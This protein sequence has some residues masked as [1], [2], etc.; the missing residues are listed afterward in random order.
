[1]KLSFSNLLLIILGLITARNSLSQSCANYSPVTRQTGIAYT[2]IAASS[3]SYFIWRN[4]AS[5]QN[6][7]NR[8]YQ[9]PIGFDFW[10][11]GVRYNQISASLNGV[12]DFSASTSQGN[13]PSG[14]SPYGSHWSNQFS[15]ANRT[16]LALAPLYGDL[17]TAN[18]GT[19]AIATSIFYKVTGTSPNQVLTVEW[20]N[21]DHWNLPTN[22]PNANYN[23]Q[24]KIYETTGVIEFVYG[25]MTA[26]AGGSY[27][28]QYACGINNT[29]T[30]GP[31]TPVRLLTQQTAN[32]TTFSST[33]KNNLTT[34]PASNSQLTFTPPTPN[35]T[36]PATLSF[37][38][39]TSSGMT[40]NFTDWCSNEVG[41]VVYNSTDNITFNFVTQTAAN[42]INYAATGLLPSTLYYWKVYAVTDGSL[43]SP[44]LGNQSTNAAGNKI[45]IA[46]GNWGTAGTWSPSGAP[47]AGDNVTI[48]N[49]HT[50]TINANN[51]TCNNLTVGQGA[52]GILRIGNNTTARIVTINNDIAI[53]TG[54]QFIANTGSNTTHNITV[55]GNII[56]NGTL[57]FASDGNSFANITFNKNG[58]QTISG[59]GA[60]TR[61]NRITVNM[62]TVNSNTLEITA[63]NFTV[64]STNFLTLTNGTFKLST[65]ATI[66][67]FTGNTT[68]PLSTGLWVNNASAV[69]NT[70]GGS[71]TLY[72]KLNVSSGTL[73]IGNATN[74]NLT[75]YG[76]VV[77][78]NG[79]SINIASRLD[80]AGTPTLSFFN[81]TNGTLTLNTVGSTTAGAAPFRMDEVG[82]TFNM[83]G[84]TIII[85]RSGAGN[86]GYVN[87]GSTGTVTGGTLQIGDA[88]TPAAQ[89]IQINST[90]EIGNLL[91]NSANANAILM[92]NSLVLTNDVTV[93]SG[94]LNAN[95]L[96]LTLGG[97]WLDN[98]TFT[99]GI[100]TV[101]FDGTNQSI[102]KTTGETF[103]HL[104]LTGTGTKT[105]G[106]NVTTNGDLTINAAA[107]LDITTN[108]YN[109]NVGSNW[110]NNGNFLAQNGTVTFNGTVAQ[111][112]GGT[113]IT[114]FRNITLNNSAGASLTNAQNLLGTLTL[115]FGTFA[116]NGQVFTLVSDASGTARIAT[117]PPFG[118]D[119]TGNIT[120]QRYIDAGATNWRFL[121]TAVSGTTLADWNDDFITSGFIGS[122][123]PLWPTP[124][125]PWSSI[126]FYDETVLGIEDS[127]YVAAT[128]ITN[129]VAVGQGVWVWSGDTIIGTQPFTIDVTGPANKGNISLPLTYTA[130]A[131]I[132]DD[133]WNM[134]GN[135]YPSTL[136][137]DSPSITKTGINNAIYIFNPDLD[138]FASYVGGFGT[139]GGSNNIASSQAFWVQTVAA[140]PSIIVTEPCKTAIDGAFLKQSNGPLTF[141]VQNGYG[142]DQTIINFESNATNNFD[143]LYDALKLASPNPNK[144]SISSLMQ[145]NSTE[146]SI[147]QLPEQEVNIFIKIKTGVSGIHNITISG[148]ANYNQSP[149][150]LLEDLFTGMVYDLKVTSSFSAY[151]YDTTLSPRFLL[152]FGAPIEVS[153][154]NLS[155]F[156]SADGKITFNKNSTT[157]F[158]ILW[159]NSLGDTISNQTSII[160]LDSITNL[161]AD[162][163]TITSSDNLCG[164]S[165]DT[166]IITEPLPI[167]AL[168]VANTDTV[169][170]SNGGTINFANQSVNASNYLWDFGDANTSTLPSPIHTYFID[171]N[172]FVNLIASQNANCYQTYTK[173]ITVLISPTGIDETINNDA[174]KAWINSDILTIDFNNS[175]FNQLQINNVL[176][177]LVY[178][179]HQDFT[180][181]FSLDVSKLKSSVFLI[182][183]TNATE[184]EVIKV[185]YIK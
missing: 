160:G 38:G 71:I 107:I 49:G 109:V 155:C 31:A 162:S 8:S 12:V 61:F 37:T 108:N 172:Y 91:V 20:L 63:T 22:S 23:F 184:V 175:S 133:G 161:A 119:I 167:T 3:P 78:F 68:L 101:T 75:S 45:S 84:G 169:Y 88:S 53:N 146:Y 9:V 76:G 110:I 96:N 51:A 168:F 81:M 85:R 74:N 35:G 174:I 178:A 104:S 152:K 27:P 105:L 41:Y 54:G 118:A 111:T 120:M 56:N 16:M 149:C 60:T 48:A 145:S 44:V 69:V 185:P 159:K 177:Q 138:D 127:G 1:M 173:L 126:Y 18:G 95:N 134:V 141:N 11:L 153:S 100:G 89:T 112:I 103:N 164:N 114:N 65:T 24:V 73:N 128:N 98:G 4:T 115:S 130:S 50:V 139:N 147:N 66:T 171:G 121:T 170:L 46:S 116:T 30:S 150:L 43:S 90:K 5:N 179:N 33:A 180:G 135:P 52:S 64:A 94:T 140:S 144:P 106:G 97:N 36:P 77:T 79:G 62:G 58:S 7:D 28:L 125:N 181:T 34:V 42:A 70:T 21:F 156:G 131:G 154:T 57:N 99:P 10:Y 158:D 19:T 117:I 13:T 29:W 165:T 142:T 40:V 15:T 25:T 67:P 124:A 182:T 136:D 14:S 176:G 17:W 72:G 87:V 137:W 39:V 2:S 82:A 59:A 157:P 163:Y 86:L 55:A 148:I 93:N 47:T 132:F 123:Y 80:K 6:D 143:A 113:S 92:T 166:V 83:T 26:V 151:I 183:L 32:S 102:T 129:T 122:D